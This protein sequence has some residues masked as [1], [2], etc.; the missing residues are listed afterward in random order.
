MP[1]IETE[2]D[3]GNY[4]YVIEELNTYLFFK[5]N[6]LKALHMRARSYEELGK[7]KEAIADYKKIIT[8]ESKYAQAHA[9]I[10]KIYFELKDYEEAELYFLR[11]ATLD[12]EDFDII[13]LLGRTQLMQEKFASAEEFLTLAKEINPKNANVHFYQ[14]MAR[15]F[16][17]DVLGC[18]ASFNN[19]VKYEP[20]NLVGLYNRGYAYMKAGYLNW[21]LED[22][23]AVLTQNPNHI[24]AMAKKGFCM[25]SLGNAE[26]CQ[27]LQTAAAKGSE[28]AKNQKE[29]CI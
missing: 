7:L 29:I 18:A 27:L 20:D 28:Y 1:S 2:F 9:G 8:L 13:Y 5:V 26:G 14:G 15:A 10:G 4:Q 12:P 11:A 24:E 21:A 23:E 25:A 16:R 17:G 22:F 6:D 3:R 19:Y